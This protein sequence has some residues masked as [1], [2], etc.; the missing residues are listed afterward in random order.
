MKYLLFDKSAI[1]YIIGCAEFQS[2]EFTIGKTF[3]DYIYGNSDSF[4]V[5]KLYAKKEKNSG[6]L[7][8]GNDCDFKHILVFDLVQSGLLDKGYRQGF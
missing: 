1:E 7:F 5:D 8:S 6:I 2:T 4:T 3:I